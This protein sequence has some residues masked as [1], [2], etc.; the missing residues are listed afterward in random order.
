MRLGGLRLYAKQCRGNGIEMRHSSP[1]CGAF[2]DLSEHPRQFSSTRKTALSNDGQLI[3]GRLNGFPP[4]AVF[5]RTGRMLHDVMVEGAR[6]IEQCRSPIRLGHSGHVVT[7]WRVTGDHFGDVCRAVVAEP[8]HRRGGEMISKVLPSFSII[9]SR[10]RHR[11]CIR[12]PSRPSQL[13][14]A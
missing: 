9:K 13:L 10:T 3:F 5:R 7:I 1:H 4:R 11:R 14:R 12:W 2:C 8:E 6:L